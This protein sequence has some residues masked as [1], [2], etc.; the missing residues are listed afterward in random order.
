MALIQTHPNTA[1]IQDGE[2]GKGRAKLRL[3]TVDE[4]VTR[5]FDIAEKAYAMA[6][7][8]G[9]VVQLPDLNEI[10]A[11]TDAKVAARSE[12]ESA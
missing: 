8:R 9:H 5:S 6:A 1:A 2:D 3:Q 12:K 11:K 10:N 7:A 4:L